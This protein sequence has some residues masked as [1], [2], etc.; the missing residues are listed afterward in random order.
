MNFDLG[1]RRQCSHRSQVIIVCGTTCVVP[2]KELVSN[3]SEKNASSSNPSGND[4]EQDGNDMPQPIRVLVKPVR[5]RASIDLIST[6][7]AREFVIYAFYLLSL[8]LL[9]RLP[10]N[11]YLFASGRPLSYT[12]DFIEAPV[13]FVMMMMLRGMACAI[14]ITI[15]RLWHAVGVI[16]RRPSAK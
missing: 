2:V 16:R 4:E 3:T 9:S 1:P 10:T 6:M 12:K 11:I 7:S 8:G 5:R 15:V 14:G 13:Y